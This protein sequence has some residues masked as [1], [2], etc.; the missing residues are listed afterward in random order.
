MLKSTPKAEKECELANMEQR[1]A[2]R[3]RL[4]D[5]DIYM[6]TSHSRRKDAGQPDFAS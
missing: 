2:E 4:Q 5:L 1:F 6:D 3:H